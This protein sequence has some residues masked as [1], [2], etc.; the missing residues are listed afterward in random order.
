MEVR[1]C[2]LALSPWRSQNKA[3]GGIC[4]CRDSYQVEERTFLPQGMGTD[5]QGSLAS[6]PFLPSWQGIENLKSGDTGPGFALHA[7]WIPQMSHLTSLGLS[8]LL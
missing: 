3:Q 7:S 1:S 4:S 5:G 2:L 6:P 8:F